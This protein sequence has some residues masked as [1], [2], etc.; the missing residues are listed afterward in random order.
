METSD[1]LEVLRSE[2]NITEYSYLKNKSTEQLQKNLEFCNENKIKIISIL[3]MKYWPLLTSIINNMFKGRSKYT[4]ITNGI[5]FIHHIRTR[6]CAPED[7][8][9]Y[10]SELYVYQLQETHIN[11]EL[12]TRTI[13]IDLEI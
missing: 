1:L 7:L 6:C 3:K 11:N 5:D 2:L 8:Y 4:Y 9:N 13:F 10:I 12:I